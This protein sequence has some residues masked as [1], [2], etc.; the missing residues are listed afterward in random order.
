MKRETVSVPSL[1][2]A[3]ELGAQRKRKGTL[4]AN[5]PRTRAISAA[6]G[7]ATTITTA[8]RQPVKQGL[9]NKPKRRNLTAI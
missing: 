3:V 2:P 5:D 1:E 7:R 6:G 8:R 4:I 9:T